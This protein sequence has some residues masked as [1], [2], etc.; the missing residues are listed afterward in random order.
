VAEIF[1][2]MILGN[3]VSGKVCEPWLLWDAITTIIEATRPR[4]MKAVEEPTVAASRLEQFGL[5]SQPRESTHGEQQS[6][7]GNR[8][9]PG[10]AASHSISDIFWTIVSLVFLAFTAVR[11]L[12]FTIATSSSL[13]SRSKTWLQ[14]Q[15]PTQSEAVHASSNSLLS[16]DQRPILSMS[17]WTIAGRVLDLDIH[18]PWLSGLF[19]LSHHIA[20][21]GPG[22]IGD[23]DGALDR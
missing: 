19:S 23:T 12:I 3:A 6:Q 7:H 4:T 9:Q 22:R 17:V 16:D 14:A 20:M 11:T 18:M 2:E 8:R 21:F 1:S 15:S 13:P 5:L 10:P